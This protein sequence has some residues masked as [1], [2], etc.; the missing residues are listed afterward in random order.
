MTIQCI[1]AGRKLSFSCMYLPLCPR[2][3]RDK[4]DI[5][6]VVR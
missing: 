3:R 1:K 4:P 2:T 6:L 5:C